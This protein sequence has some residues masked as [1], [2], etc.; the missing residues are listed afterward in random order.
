MKQILCEEVTEHEELIKKYICKVVKF[1]V[2]S[3]GE[4][5]LKFEMEYPNKFIMT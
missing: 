2:F 1:V 5:I 4:G 3:L